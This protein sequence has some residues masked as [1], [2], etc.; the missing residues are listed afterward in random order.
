MSE[1]FLPRTLSPIKGYSLYQKISRFPE[2]LPQMRNAFLEVLLE[3]GITT[4]EQLSSLAARQ[5]S[6]DGVED[7]EA[8][9][10]EY[11]DALIDLLFA[12]NLSPEEVENHV[13]LV[14]KRDKCQ[15]L[16]RVVASDHTSALTIWRAL[17][18]FC[19]IPKG[20]LYISREEAEG[21][22]VSLLSY[23]ISAQLPF[24]GI[25]KNHVTIRDI[26]TILG[27]TIGH[28]KYPGKLGGKAAGM[29]VAQ[30]ILLPIL[31]ERDPEFERRIAV[32][33]TWYITSG[34]FSD[35]IDR[36]HFYDFHTH[37][38]RDRE[39]IEEEYQRVGGLFEH[40]DFSP[41][42]VED[43][44]GL[45]RQ[46]GEHPIIVRSSSYL[47]DNFGFAFS[48]KYQSIF[49]A[50]QGSEEARLEQ[51]IRGVKTVLASMYGP[52]PIIYRRDHGLLDFNERMAMI[53]QK[54]VGRRFGDWFFPLAAGVMYSWNSWAW[55]QKIRKRDGLVR[56]VFGLGTRAVDRVG[57]DYPRMIPLSHPWM[58][59][60]VTADQIQRYSQKMVD[61]INLRTGALETVD[62]RTLAAETGHPDLH[63]AVSVNADGQMRAPLSRLQELPP[64][65]L[66]L[67]FENFDCEV[68]V[69]APCEEGA[70]NRPGR[71]WEARGHGVRLG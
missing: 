27:N 30:K 20:E 36:N 62:F 12:N 22:R 66:C 56:L 50:N 46:I 9:R 34:V 54:V 55:N 57:G 42:V 23:F 43:F 32:P 35:F 63:L 5:M 16:G 49:L 67:T 61:A 1:N 26:D 29:I 37:K 71:I 24:V 15:E 4:P 48:G 28:V 69:R 17:R 65:S 52:D 44:R 58:R 18:E 70:R 51:F 41:D 45:I 68:C 8:N 13:N 38:Y 2:L 7:T 60:E 25:A 6:A 53:V 39:G 40:A 47:E 3:R 19:E 11:R 59:P 31:S 14:R 10:A 21:I 33:D 64:A